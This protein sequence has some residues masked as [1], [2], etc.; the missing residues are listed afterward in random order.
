[1]QRLVGN[2]KHPLL[3]QWV[4]VGAASLSELEAELFDEILENAQ[5]NIA[6]W[7]EEDLKM[8]FVSFVLRLGHLR[9]N[10]LFNIY[11]EKTISAT[12][13]GHFLKTKTDFMVAKGIL[14]IPEKPYFHFQEWKPQ[15][16]P[17][18]DSMAQLLEA[19]LIAQDTNQ[20]DQ[21]LY[22]CEVIGKQWNFVIFTDRTYCT[23]KSYDCT[24]QEDLLQIIAI[25]RK[26]KEILETRLL[27]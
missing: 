9:D 8:K 20:D 12:I 10:A 22:G 3:S 27:K 14:N 19:F 1:L 21:P 11:F 18:G 26:F 7:Q 25:L 5:Q 15:K 13:D 6:G 23:S 17:V 2:E 4:N 24:D 16:K